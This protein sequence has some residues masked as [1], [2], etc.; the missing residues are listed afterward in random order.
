MK[1]TILR[2]AA[3]LLATMGYV[4]VGIALASAG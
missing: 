3:V 4:I 1:G 2:A